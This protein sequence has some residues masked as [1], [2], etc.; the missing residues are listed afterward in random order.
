MVINGF[1][2]TLF[3][4]ILCLLVL[5]ILGA[6]PFVLKAKGEGEKMVAAY[7]KATEEIF[8][9]E[10]V[11]IESVVIKPEF[12]I[13]NPPKALKL[14]KMIPSRAKTKKFRTITSMDATMFGFMKMYTLLLAPRAGYNFP[15]LSFDVVSLG[16]NRVFVIEVIDPAHIPA[17]YI[18]SAYEKMKTLKEKVKD[19]PDTPPDMPWAK[20]MTMDFSIHTKADNTREEFFL[21]L[22]KE[23][24]TTYLEMVGSAPQLADE[25]QSRKVQEGIKTYVNALLEKGGPAVNVFKFL[26]GPEKQEEFVKGIMFGVEE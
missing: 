20:E 17:E 26:L 7:Q 11:E 3:L 19:L 25:E 15:M 14:I 13:I 6:T 2:K 1:I 24:L 23:Y 9:K 4:I 18:T 8:R 16:K 10:G 5:V 22:Y 21:S 12:Q